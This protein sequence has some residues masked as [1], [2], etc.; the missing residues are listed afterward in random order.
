M[1]HSK[2]MKGNAFLKLNFVQTDPHLFQWKPVLSLKGTLAICPG[3]SRLHFSQTGDYYLKVYGNFL[4]LT[5]CNLWTRRKCSNQIRMYFI[6]MTYLS[7]LY[8][9]TGAWLKTLQEHNFGQVSQSVTINIALVWK[10]AIT[11][12]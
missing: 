12:L 5:P 2:R 8:T 9:D 3:A 7:V 6:L 10:G 1:A 4:T 11:K